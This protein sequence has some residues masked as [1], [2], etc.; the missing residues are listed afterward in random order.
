MVGCS[1][2]PGALADDSQAIGC[3]SFDVW[4]RDQ[5]PEYVI[6]MTGTYETMDIR[7]RD[8]KTTLKPGTA[9]FAAYYR[10]QL[11]QAIRALGSTGAVVIITTVPCLYVPYFPEALREQTVMNPDRLRIENQLLL[12][13]ATRPEYRG[14]VIVA[15]LNHFLCPRGSSPIEPRSRQAG[16]QRRRAFHGGRR[17]AGGN[18]AAPTGPEAA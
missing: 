6:L 16:A 5:A 7:P 17:K 12:E 2:L 15:D 13:V 3:G 1:L 8:L 18:L 11:E 14:R 10:T 9:A 4:T